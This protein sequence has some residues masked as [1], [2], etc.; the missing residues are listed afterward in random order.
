MRIARP[1]LRV[2]QIHSV[3]GLFHLFHSKPC[4]FAQGIRFPING[5]DLTTAG[6]TA[7]QA[8]VGVRFSPVDFYKGLA[9]SGAADALR[10]AT[11]SAARPL[12]T[13]RWPDSVA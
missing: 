1:L 6:R 3:R 5:V 4:T 11:S 13:S 12:S 2:I 9:M 10:D 7:Y 8:R